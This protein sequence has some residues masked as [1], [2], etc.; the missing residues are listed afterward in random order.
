MLFFVVQLFDEGHNVVT[1]NLPKAAE[2]AK[3][4]QKPETKA[5]EVE[6]IPVS[7]AQVSKQVLDVE[8]EDDYEDP[9]NGIESLAQQVPPEPKEPGIRDYSIDVWNG[10]PGMKH[11]GYHD[12]RTER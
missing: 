6:D 7:S 12:T 11:W 9:F 10:S 2:V 5:D 4:T 1:M 8:Y 3:K